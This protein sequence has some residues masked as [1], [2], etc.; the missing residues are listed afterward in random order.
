MT[1]YFAKNLKFI[2][3]NKKI[4]KNKLGEMVGVN[5]S[6]ITRWE[7]EEIKPSIDNVEEVAQALKIPLPD[8]LIKDL[9]IN[10]DVSLNNQYNDE[11][12]IL[13]DKSKDILTESDKTVIR[14][15][16]EQRKKE[17]DKELD[18]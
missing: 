5:Q 18:K 2:R 11:F 14:T 16:I 1:N 12:A 6:T 7:S 10:N 17:I 9:E 8:L 13:F 3:E 15:I 4:S